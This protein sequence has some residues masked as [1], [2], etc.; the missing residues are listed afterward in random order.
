MHIHTLTSN[1]YTPH[2]SFYSHWWKDPIVIGSWGTH[3]SRSNTKSVFLGHRTPSISISSRNLPWDSAT[4]VPQIPGK[5]ISVYDLPCGQ[6]SRGTGS[7]TATD[8]NS[9][10]QIP[11]DMS[12]KRYS[13]HFT[14]EKNQANAKWYFKDGIDIQRFESNPAVTSP[15]SCRHTNRISRATE[16]ASAS[17]DSKNDA[18]VFFISK[19]M[20][21]L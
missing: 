6:A 17:L 19:I 13:S 4:E 2:L 7:A 5:P 14:Y 20:C 3:C 16:S 11:R 1:I 15:L 12:R 9:L 18:N 8:S 10:C 21:T